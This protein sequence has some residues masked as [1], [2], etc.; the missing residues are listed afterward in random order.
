[1][2]FWILNKINCFKQFETAERKMKTR[3]LLKWCTLAAF[4]TIWDCSEKD[5]GQ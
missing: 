4:E 3:T 1:M 2:A 5:Q